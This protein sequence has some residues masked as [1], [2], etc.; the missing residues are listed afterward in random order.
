VLRQAV[1]AKDRNRTP[2]EREYEQ[3]VTLYRQYLTI[4]PYTRGTPDEWAV[5][6]KQR[7]ELAANR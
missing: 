1:S 4:P 2:M 7:S 3:A 6:A 5:V